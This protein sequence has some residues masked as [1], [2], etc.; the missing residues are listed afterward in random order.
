MSTRCDQKM[1]FILK[2]RELRMFDYRFSVM[3]VHM[4]VIYVENISHFVL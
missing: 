3:F 2:F 1:T 4:S